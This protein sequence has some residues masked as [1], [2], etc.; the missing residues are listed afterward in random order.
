[1]ISLNI[2]FYKALYLYIYIL[3]ILFIFLIFGYN[4]YIGFLLIIEFTAITF[5][6]SI[7]AEFNFSIF[8]ENK[9]YNIYYI[10]SI[11]FISI[12]INYHFFYKFNYYSYYY[13][14]YNNF[15][16]YINN[17]IIGIYNLLFKNFNSY[18]IILYL[19]FLIFTLILIYFFFNYIT[20]LIIKKTYNILYYIIKYIKNKKY[21]KNN[22]I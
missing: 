4:Q 19:S 5:I 14:Y 6:I 9:L 12:F 22:Y 16:Y 10:I 7:I 17:D 18:I 15:I 21:I 3:Y 11:L 20:P 13:N 8:L 1:M 2:Y